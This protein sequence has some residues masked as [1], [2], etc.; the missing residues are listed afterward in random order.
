MQQLTSFPPSSLWS[1]GGG[2]GRASGG[3][4]CPAELCLHGVREDCETCWRMKPEDAADSRTETCCGRPSSAG[5]TAA[6]PE[7]VSTPEA[8]GNVRPLYM[9]PKRDDARLGWQHHF[10]ALLENN[11]YINNQVFMQSSAQMTMVKVQELLRNSYSLRLTLRRMR[12]KT[13]DQ[14]R[15]EC[16]LTSGWTSPLHPTLETW[17]EH[18]NKLLVLKKRKI[19]QKETKKKHPSFQWVHLNGVLTNNL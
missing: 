19:Y 9:K 2:G 12:Q 13:A 10:K 3:L 17:E 4:V 7:N 14:S 18:K 8:D 16:R 11:K 5:G 15:K 6:C 1:R